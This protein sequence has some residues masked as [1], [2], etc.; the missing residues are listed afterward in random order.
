VCH[1]LCQCWLED[2]GKASGTPGHES[3][4]TCTSKGMASKQASIE[5]VNW[6]LAQAH[7]A[8][9]PKEPS[10]LG[11]IDTKALEARLAELDRRRV[12]LEAGLPPPRRA[13][14]LADGTGENEHLFI[15]GSHKL[16]GD[17]VPRRMLEVIAGGNQPAIAQG[18]GRLELARR[19]TAA[20]NPL[21]A[22]VLVNRVWQH[23]FGRG[24]VPTPDDFGVMGRAPSHPELLDYLAA[25][26]KREGWSIKK[27]HRQLVLSSAYRMASAAQPTADAADPT[28]ALLHRANARRIEAECIRDTLLAVSGRLDRTPFGPGVPPHLTPFMSGRGRPT[29]SG[30]L[31]GAGRRSIYLTVRR[32]FLMPMLLAFDYPTPFTTIGRRSESNVPAQAL[33]MM[34]S[35]LVWE[36]AGVWTKQVLAAPEQSAEARITGMY[37]RALG[38]E[39]AREELEA[40]LEFLREQAAQY[41]D[42]DPKRVWTDLAHVLFNTKEF[43]YVQ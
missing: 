22:R 32:N 9:P 15:R 42:T 10:L 4:G 19:M 43:V 11:P 31:D 7:S 18:S 33:V 41:G 28:N 29:T 24:I 35:P 13:M 12:Q 8:K 25:E 23:H 37:H 3:P 38:R 17:E 21:L 40:A 6:L 14:A 27:L 30:P 34:N 36:Q 26:F 2:T 1:W 20:S 5:I 39:P 16:L